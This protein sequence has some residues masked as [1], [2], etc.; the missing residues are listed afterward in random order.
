MLPGND[1]DA[2]FTDIERQTGRYPSANTAPLLKAP[3]S[4]YPDC[5][6]LQE[7]T[8]RPLAS[9]YYVFSKV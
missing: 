2:A 8:G 7:G 5:E 3:T 4:I 9:R 6:L 1:A